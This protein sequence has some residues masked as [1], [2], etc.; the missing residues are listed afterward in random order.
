MNLDKI[1]EFIDRAQDLADALDDLFAEFSQ[2]DLARASLEGGVPLPAQEG[3]LALV[4]WR[5][6][7]RALTGE[8]AT[9]A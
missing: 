5:R 7:I 6:L 9:V 2:G 4:G 3:E 1:A 8:A